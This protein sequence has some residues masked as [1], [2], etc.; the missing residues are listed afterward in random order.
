MMNLR[1]FPILTRNPTASQ[2]LNKSLGHRRQSIFPK[3][4]DNLCE[5]ALCILCID[6]PYDNKMLKGQQ[7]FYVMINSIDYLIKKPF[8]QFVT[9][10]TVYNGGECLKFESVR[11]SIC[12]IQR[13]MKLRPV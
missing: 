12:A 9:N 2:F 10:V 13:R 5:N 11:G 6:N 4:P 1:E 8:E 7:P 3:I